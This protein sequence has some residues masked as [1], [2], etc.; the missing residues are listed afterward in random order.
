MSRRQREV[1]AE[2][3]QRRTKKA[4]ADS[5]SARAGVPRHAPHEKILQAGNAA[6]GQL[7]NDS[8]GGKP[9]QREARAK[10]EQ[11]FGADFSDVRVHDDANAQSKAG[12]LKARAVTRGRDIYLGPKAPPL[13]S[14][15]GSKLL[16]HELAHVVQQD[17]GS[18]SEGKVNEPGDQFEQAA[19]AAAS[20]VVQGQ[21]ANL[22]SSGTPPGVQRDGEPASRAELEATLTEFLQRVLQAQGG[23]TL[24]VTAEVRNAVEMLAGA[25]DPS[26]QGPGGDPGRGIRLTAIQTWLNGGVVPG[27]PEAFAREVAR[28]LPNPFNAE[29]LERLRR[30]RAAPE[31]TTVGR[32]RQLVEGS[33]PGTPDTRREPPREPTS[34][35]RF[36]RGMEDLNRQLGRPQPTTYGPYSL[37]VLRI[38]RILGGLRQA[39]RGPQPQPRPEP[40]AQNY[41]ELERAI[42]QISPNALVPAEARGGPAAGDF[43]DAR[44]MARQLARL[45]DVAQQQVRDSV[46]LDLGPAYNNVRNRDAIVAEVGRI[47]RAIRDALPHH[48]T[49]VRTVIVRIGSHD[50]WIP[51]GQPRAE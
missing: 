45:L 36:E 21:A 39:V 28:R 24:R 18:V 44:E 17:Q 9:I 51:V 12:A 32:V 19:D 42:Q 43:A 22:Q 49:N 3:P 10:M 15:A 1:K 31:S 48:A 46:N 29:A 20:R 25:P 13:D 34:T 11:A 50:S 2:D 4:Q 23:R 27:D 5:R 26:Y 6:V 8:H 14:G 47:V 40:E 35:E 7:L 33:A 30:M 38:G 37:D 16:A 41:P